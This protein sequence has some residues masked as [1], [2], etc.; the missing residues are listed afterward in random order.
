M[1]HAFHN[2]LHTYYSADPTLCR[3]L[4]A[5]LAIAT[6]AGILAAASL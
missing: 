4:L 6:Y 3:I 2:T 1:R 5:L